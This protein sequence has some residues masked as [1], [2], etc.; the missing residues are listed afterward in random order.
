[1][2]HESRHTSR[3]S[4][5]SIIVF[6]VVSLIVG[7]LVT[8]GTLSY[9]SSK[10]SAQVQKSLRLPNSDYPLINPL[11]LCSTDN[12]SMNEDKKIESTIKNF[13]NQHIS[14]KLAEDMSVYLIN[15]TT[16]QWAGV[17]ENV[18]YDPAS[19]LKV[20]IMI[21][22]YKDAEKDPTVLDKQISFNG[23][24]QNSGEYFKS[25][26]DITAGTSYTTDTL[27]RSMIVNSDNTAAV[28]LQNSIDQTDLFDTFTDLGLPIPSEGAN[29]EYMSAKSYA[30]FFRIL[31]NSTYLNDEY[32]EKALTLLSQTTGPGIKAGVPAG[33]TVSE[34]F[35]ERSVYDTSGNVLDRELHAC[36]IVYKTGSPYLLCIMSKGQNFDS[37]AKNI[38]DLSTLVYQDIN[39]Q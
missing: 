16:G 4:T 34:K 27:I 10:N 33:V 2:S 26:Q 6:S 3:H 25:A 14:Q 12:Q 31:Y 7:S 9:A 20:P 21:A 22:Y 8:W 23:D 15:Y 36:G 5:T 39:T 17:N 30:S 29:V 19:M 1:M 13:V 11:L 24:D 37:M 32:S 18:R 38:S 28:L 35:G